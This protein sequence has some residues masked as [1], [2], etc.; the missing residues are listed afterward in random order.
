MV[1]AE[2]LSAWEALTMERPEY[3]KLRTT[4]KLLCDALG[5]V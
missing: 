5:A 3:S 4:I 1:E 2:L